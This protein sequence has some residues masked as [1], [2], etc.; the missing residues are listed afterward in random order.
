VFL[1]LPELFK[2]SAGAG[3]SALN[4]F[5]VGDIDARKATQTSERSPARPLRTLGHKVETVPFGKIGHADC[6]EVDPKTNGFRAV[7]D[8][9]RGGGGAVAY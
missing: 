7:A 4:V 2:L 6:I 8:V 5:F 1:Q 9:T 3:K